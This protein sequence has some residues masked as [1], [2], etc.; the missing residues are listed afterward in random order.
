MRAQAKALPVALALALAVV[1]APVLAGSAEAAGAAAVEGIR[2]ISEKGYSR[3]VID[4][5]DDVSFSKN[6]IGN[7]DRVFVDLK[8]FLKSDV[9]RRFTV[10]DGLLRGI[11]AGQNNPKT[12]RVV[13]DLRK[14][15]SYKV[16]TLT[17]PHRLVIDVYADR[18]APGPAAD[19][20]EVKEVPKPKEYFSKNKRPAVKRVVLDAGHGGHD[21]GAVSYGI[22]EKDIA[23]DIAKRIKRILEGRGG[24]EVYLT[25]ER[26]KFLSLESRTVI[27]NE[28]GADL[29]VSIHTNAHKSKKIS[30]IET[31]Y[32]NYTNNRSA[33]K[34]A[35]RENMISERRMKRAR[36]EKDVILASLTLSNNVNESVRLAGHVQSSMVK[37][38]SG[39]YSSVR[40]LGVK[41]ALFYVLV[42][43]KMPSVLCEVAFI[44]NPTEA[45]RLKTSKYREHLARGIAKGIDKYFDTLPPEQKVAMR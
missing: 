11:R 41:Y 34:V 16:F 45:R 36:S 30:G 9:K 43:A 29:F 7:P 8:G 38:V 40:S 39:K 37:Q 24:Y 23:I 25:R 14:V 26:D 22:K 19:G 17:D 28:K 12:V 32:L 18:P 27:A 42:G 20:R 35:A 33:L 21:P 5:T 31:Y 15:G 1:L 6:R 44:T 3:V 10:D 4:L 13:L 2:Y